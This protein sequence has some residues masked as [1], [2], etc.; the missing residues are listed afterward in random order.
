MP[1]NETP[2]SVAGNSAPLPA[3]S[4]TLGLPGAASAEEVKSLSNLLRGTLIGLVGSIL[5][6]SIDLLSQWNLSER[7]AVLEQKVFEQNSELLTRTL[8]QEL[9]GERIEEEIIFLKECLS[10]HLW[11]ACLK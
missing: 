8:E 2:E 1:D 3:T 10:L 11:K 4:V 9:L 7:V 5:F 6:L